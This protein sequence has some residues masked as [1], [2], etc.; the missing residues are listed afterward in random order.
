M[1]VAVLFIAIIAFRQVRNLCRPVILLTDHG[2]S[3]GRENEGQ[4]LITRDMLKL[5][6]FHLEA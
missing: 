3:G 5:R 4:G 1:L 2:M 6:G